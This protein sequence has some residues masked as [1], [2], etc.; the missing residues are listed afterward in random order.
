MSMPKTHNI[1]A[2]ELNEDPSSR[3][4]S[5]VV[6]TSMSLILGVLISVG[7]VVGVLGK[8]FYVTRSEFNDK[9][10]NDA[11]QD[12]EVKQTLDSVNHFLSR[13]EGVIDRMADSIQKIQVDMARKGK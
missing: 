11:K 7:F 1:I 4:K 3:R 12:T 13:Q 10:V 9:I 6:L 2:A 5:A 8:A